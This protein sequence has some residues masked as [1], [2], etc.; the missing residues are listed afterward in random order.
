MGD[1]LAWT[2]S[3]HYSHLFD[4]ISLELSMQNPF[5]NN[6]IDPWLPAT[7]KLRKSSESICSLQD[8]LTVTYLPH[9]FIQVFLSL[10][11]VYGVCVCMYVHVHAQVCKHICLCTYGGQKII[12]L[13]IPLAP[14]ILYLFR[15]ESLAGLDLPKA[16][17]K[18][19]GPVGLRLED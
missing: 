10:L 12:L 3:P 6:Q 17:Q 16:G 13:V 18:S 2:L 5:C 9:I 14:P 7:Q 8:F 19:Q 11:C 4:P 1:K 15:I